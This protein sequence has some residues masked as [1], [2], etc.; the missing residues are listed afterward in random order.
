MRAL[1]FPKP[2][3]TVYPRLRFADLANLRRLTAFNQ[4]AFTRWVRD[5]PFNVENE[6]LLVGLLQQLSINAEWD[7]DYV[8]AYTRF[9]AYSLCTLF[10]ITSLHHVG[11]ATLEG[12]YRNN[13]REHWCLI[14][15]TKEYKEGTVGLHTLTPVMPLCS[16]VITRGYSH[17]LTRRKEKSNAITD[18][19]VIGVDIVELAVGWWLYQRLNRT[20]DTGPGAYIA[21]YPF[22]KAQLV[23]NQLSI[24]N[25][26]YDHV[27]HDVPLESLIKT[28]KVLFTTANE[29][30]CIVKYLKFLIAYYDGHRMQNFEH[31]LSALEG[32]Y[33]GDHFNYV[34]AGKSALFAQTMWVWEPGIL[35]LY[36]V[37]LTFCNKN[38]YKVNDIST[39]ISRTHNERTQE[40]R[41]I[42]ESY[43]KGWFVDLADEVL[44]LNKENFKL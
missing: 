41:R 7:L 28:D 34:Q 30:A 1:S 26:L 16:T 25:I 36:A 19:A 31:F 43:F 17:N 29:E 37:Y 5:Q 35:K 8:V 32:L 14:E 23:H 15:N 44:A 38:K 6:H 4:K 27:V 22:V 42:P 9:R 21:Q 18:L 24:I 11:E 33:E 12:F 2:S 20:R 39:I 40:Y 10:K 13:T 3:N